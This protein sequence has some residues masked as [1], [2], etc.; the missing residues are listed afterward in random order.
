MVRLV[1]ARALTAQGDTDSAK[2]LVSDAWRNDPIPADV[3]KQV[4]D[5]YSDFLSRADHKARMEK[6]L[7]AADK[8]SAMRAA[9]RLG[10]ADL[11][12]ANLRL[13]LRGKGGGTPRKLLDAAPEGAPRDAGSRLAPPDLLRRD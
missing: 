6:R 11:A 7:V 10:G 1:L 9:K 2:A 5:R 4:L 12:L 8:D 13:P 3:E